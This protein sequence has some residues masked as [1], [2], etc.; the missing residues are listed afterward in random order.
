MNFKTFQN[1]SSDFHKKYY[2]WHTSGQYEGAEESNLKFEELISNPPFRESNEYYSEELDMIDQF[3]VNLKDASVLELGCGDGN[4]TWKLANKC[5]Y[6][7]SWDID[8]GGVELTKQRLDELGI[9][10][11]NILNKNVF[12]IDPEKVSKQFDVVLFIQVL[13][14]IPSWDQEECFKKVFSLVN[15]DG[16]CLFISTPNRWTLKDSHDTGKYLIHW[17]PRFIKVPIAKVFGFGLKIHDPSW[18]YP[19]VLHDYVS[20]S[21]LKRKAKKFHKGKIRTSRMEYFPDMDV[22]YN[23]KTNKKGNRS[24]LTYNL[25]KKVG[26]LVNLNYYFGSKV[27][28]QKQQKAG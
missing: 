9:K 16:G 14:H 7:E 2:R 27:I 8:N 6:L 18:P 5:K 10:N 12:E 19:P 26:K 22:W 24:K 3:F 11:V 13:E 23:I 25:L 15:S 21:W 17:L 28:I 20:F 4:L 1:L